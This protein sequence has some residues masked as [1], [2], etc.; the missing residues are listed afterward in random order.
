[1]KLLEYISMAD[2]A[3]CHE[4]KEQ[5][6]YIMY[7]K[8]DG[9]VSNVCQYCNYGTDAVNPFDNTITRT[10]DLPKEF[11]TFI[12]TKERQRLGNNF[13]SVYGKRPNKINYSSKN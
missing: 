9:S 12:M 2:W 7:Y 1:M 13:D 11:T 3:T 5:H 4:C 8:Q 10:L 6:P